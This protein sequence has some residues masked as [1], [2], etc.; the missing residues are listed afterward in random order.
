MCVCVHA[1]LHAYVHVCII[2]KEG[3]TSSQK[4][5]LYKKKVHLY[6]THMLYLYQRRYIFI[7]EGYIFMK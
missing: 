1:F 3:K 5:H 2:I 4:V 6:Q 7:K